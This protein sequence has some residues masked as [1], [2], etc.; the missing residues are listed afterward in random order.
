MADKALTAVRQHFCREYCVNGH[1]AAQAYRTAYP[2]TRSGYNA[3]GA[4]LIAK[5]SIKQEIRRLE[6]KS[7]LKVDYDI[8]QCD[9][10]Y[11][12]IIALAIKLKQPS[13]AVSAITGRARL[14]GW[15]KDTQVTTEQPIELTPEQA[16]RYGRMADAA[17]AEQIAGPKLSKEA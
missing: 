14:R 12:D 2:N 16:E 7:V 3:H 10:Q 15:D 1:N 8:E 5:D 17:V 4:R 11:S 9:R 6:A 13:A